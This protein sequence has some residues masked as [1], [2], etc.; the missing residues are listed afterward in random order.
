MK[1]HSTALR[2]VSWMKHTFDYSSSSRSRHHYSPLLICADDTPRTETSIYLPGLLDVEKAYWLCGR[3]RT[4]GP[5]VLQDPP[6][7]G[8]IPCGHF[9]PV[10]RPSH[11]APYD[12]CC[13]HF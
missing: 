5:L 11:R 12:R 4:C 6:D 10:D 9:S 7:V 1:S 3:I 8:T 13:S 2:K